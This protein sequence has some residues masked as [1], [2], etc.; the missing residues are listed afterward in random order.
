MDPR[1]I[2]RF[3]KSTEILLLGHGVVYGLRNGM[4]NAIYMP[5]RSLTSD[6]QVEHQAGWGNEA[7]RPSQPADYTLFA[8]FCA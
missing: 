6:F 2:S 5:S 4:N 1:I 8:R 7:D 3:K